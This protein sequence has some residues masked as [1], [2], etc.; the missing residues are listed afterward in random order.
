MSRG[1]KVV[2]SYAEQ[3]DVS[4]VP[5]TGW[6][7]LPRKSDSLNI[8]IDMT[9]SETIVD[10]RI[11]TAGAP[12]SATADGGIECEFIK[13]AYDKLLAA[14]AGNPWV[15]GTP[16]GTATLTFG[17]DVV[18]QFAIEKMHKDIDQYHLWTGMQVNSMKLDIPEKG[19]VSLT[20]D[21][22]GS[23]YKNQITTRYATNPTAP[24]TSPKATSLS[25]GDIKING[26]TL[27]GV[28]CVTAF[29]FELTNNIENQACIGSGL[30][31]AS[32]LTMLS[33]MTGAMTLAYGQK[34][35]SILNNQMTGAPIK[36]EALIKFGEDDDDSYLLTIPKAQ[37]SGAI[38]AGGKDKLEAQLTYSV[39]ADTIED[40]PTIV[41]VITP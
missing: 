29:S 3:S 15:E 34:A 36:I 9:D 6:E 40:A 12:T 33:D 10:S 31:G 5:L 25:V 28:A 37:V 21:F 16:D 38:P 8:T 7:V 22:M 39:Y 35:Q 41:R 27:R 23:D 2:L 20:F 32:L 13:S 30:Y 17:G 11:K 1:T 26:S 18:K 14:A 4:V 19:Y 24:I